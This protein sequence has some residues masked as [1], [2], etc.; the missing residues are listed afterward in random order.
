MICPASTS[1]IHTGRSFSTTVGGFTWRSTFESTYA[2]DAFEATMTAPISIV[3]ATRC[4]HQSD[5]SFAAGFDLSVDDFAI[6]PFQTAAR[7]HE[8]L[9]FVIGLWGGDS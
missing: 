8:R 3:A 1:L 2:S 7:S 4:N 6:G 5:F 9:S